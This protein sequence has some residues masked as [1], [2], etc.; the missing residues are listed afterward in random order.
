[1]GKSRTYR[2]RNVQSFEVASLLSGRDGQAAVV[3]VDVS[4]SSLHMVVYWPDRNVSAPIVVQQPGQLDEAM[5]L[6]KRIGQGRDLRVALEPTGSYG[7]VFRYACHGSGLTVERVSPVASSR[8]AEVYDNVPSQ[9]DGKDAG[10]IAELAFMGKS[11][12]WPWEQP[13]E[14]ESWA[15]E[16]AAWM[17]YSREEMER[18]RGRLEGKLARH[19]PEVP[20]LLALD[21]ATLLRAVEY[22]QSPARL[23]A[24]REAST[25]LARWGG[26]MLTAEKIAAIVASAGSS[27]GVPVSVAEAYSIKLI[28][29]KMLALGEEIEKHRRELMRHSQ[30]MELVKLAGAALGEATMAIIELDGGRPSDYTSGQAYLKALGL[31]LTE[32][33]SG[34][35]HGRLRISK[36]GPGRARKW[37]YL[38]ALRLLDAPGVAEW[39]QAKV[40]R[41]GGVKMK[42]I[43][44]VM[45]RVALGIHHCCRT[46]EAFDTGRLF[47]K[48]TSRRGGGRRRKRG[49]TG[50]GSAVPP[51]PANRDKVASGVGK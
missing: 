24:D 36:R 28:C 31:N 9:H 46:G 8:H 6:L 47:Q 20:H 1:M 49:R 43:I 10:T 30:A 37:L 14:D 50:T 18:W 13:S 35:H 12:R 22:Y 16:D 21:S 26:H 39:Y 19:W 32:R 5:V 44:A 48:R 42:A 17:D 29:S 25:R 7:D 38:L 45:R 2:S 4:K 27:K 15:R 41:D 34:Q 33:S 23:A 3:G 51:L 11:K 40:K